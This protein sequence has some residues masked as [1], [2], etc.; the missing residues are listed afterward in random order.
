[1]T[2]TIGQQLQRARREAGAT[3]E[4]ASKATHI[5]PRF[6]Q[7]L[8]AD[9]IASLPSIVQGRGFL[10]LYADFLR[11]DA[12]PLL[13]GFA[14]VPAAAAPEP[15]PPAAAVPVV[16][17]ALPASEPAGEPAQEE[18]PGPVWTPAEPPSMPEV[19]VPEEATP[20]QIDRSQALLARSQELFDEIGR[21]LRR[22]RELLSLSLGDVERYTRLRIHYLKSLEE[23]RM[24]DMPSSVQAR[25]MLANYARFL[26]LDADTLLLRFAAALQARREGVVALQEP[27]ERPAAQVVRHPTLRRLLSLD[28]I[29]ASGLIVMLVAFIVWGA[30]QVMSQRTQTGRPTATPPSVSEVLL[31]APTGAPAGGDAT[32]TGSVTQEAT[33]AVETPLAPNPAATLQVTLPAGGDGA[34]EVYVVARQRAWLQ[35]TVDNK[36]KFN[37]RLVPGNAYPFSGSKSIEL[38]TGNAAGLQVFYNGQDLG[39]LGN[40]GEVVN[41]IYSPDAILSPTPTTAPTATKTVP[42][43]RTPPASP[44][45]KS[46]ATPKPTATKP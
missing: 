16:E 9:D 10:R 43:T 7:A 3:I 24:Q 13:E 36:V 5:R 38:L 29:V 34:V 31:A 21:D 39:P 27:N 33:A 18:A 11:L 28:L 2:E 23:G 19:R 45:P 44:T 41:I 1:M 8:E 22:Q 12:G 40:L 37:G 25:G 17:Q 42:A 15:V 14:V 26:N 20:R 46:T 32:A 4:D 6:L 30:S 35:V